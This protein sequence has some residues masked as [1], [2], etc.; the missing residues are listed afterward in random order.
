MHLKQL[1]WVTFMVISFASFAGKNESQD[2]AYQFTFT[3]LSD[4]AMPLSKYKGDVILIVNTASKC[5]L[6]P[7]Y[8]NL[9]SLYEHYKQDGLVVVGVPSPDFANQEFSTPLEVQN[10]TQ[11][12]YSISFPMTSITHVK[13]KKAHPFYQWALVKLGDKA[14][15]KWNFH[16]ILIDKKG[17]AVATFTSF[18]DPLSKP[19][20]E[21]IRKELEKS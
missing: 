17:N 20:Q 4:K 12:E 3:S 7:Q 1:L 10:F 21:A 16:K 8:G 19:V 13:G 18:Q 9:Q 6:T 5:G 2:N 11:Q 15:P 14:I